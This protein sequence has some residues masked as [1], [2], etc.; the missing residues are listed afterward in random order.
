MDFIRGTAEANNI[1]RVVTM[2]TQS[3]SG[4]GWTQN[5]CVTSFHLPSVCVICR[6]RISQGLMQFMDGFCA[7]LWNI[8]Q[9]QQFYWESLWGKGHQW[10]L[11]KNLIWEISFNF[12]SFLLVL[13]EISWKLSGN[14][15]ISGKYPFAKSLFG[16][17]RIW[18]LWTTC[19]K[20]GH[21]DQSAH[22]YK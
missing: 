14:E 5:F 2:V 20:P 3:P 13:W 1:T 12:S 7:T 8:I 9:N 10:T 17:V 22:Y 11:L 6:P 19:M 21:N 16:Y 4:C 18:T 15:E